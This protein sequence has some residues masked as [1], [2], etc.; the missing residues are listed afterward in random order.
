LLIDSCCLCGVV[1][2][3]KNHRHQRNTHS[4][5]HSF[6]HPLE[7]SRQEWPH[8]RSI[9]NIISVFLVLTRIIISTVNERRTFLL[10]LLFEGGARFENNQPRLD[11]TSLSCLSCHALRERER[12]RESLSVSKRLIFTVF[13]SLDLSMDFLWSLDSLYSLLLETNN[14]NQCMHDSRGITS[15]HLSLNVAVNRVV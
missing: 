12:E 9:K 2:V 5:T 6:I 3:E 11:L 4:F 1:L 13:A 14:K 8:L 15:L 10:T 7:Q